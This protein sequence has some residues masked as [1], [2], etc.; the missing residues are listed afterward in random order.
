[1]YFIFKK[2]GIALIDA[3]NIRIGM[4]TNGL[5]FSL[6]MIRGL[7][8]LGIRNVFT[9]RGNQKHRIIPRTL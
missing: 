5:V 7:I 2:G 9:S 6:L 1:M 8:L 3:K 4:A